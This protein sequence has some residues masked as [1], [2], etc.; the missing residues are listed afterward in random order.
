MKTIPVV[1][2]GA[3][4]TG[5]TAATLLAQYGVE[6]L[7][8]ERWESVYPQP[9][10]VALDDEVHR[11]LARLGLRDEFAAISRPHLGLRLLDRD[12]RVLTEFRRDVAQS[13]HGYPQG[14]MFDQPELEAILRRN[15]KQYGTVTLR[16]NAEVTALTQDADGVRVDFTDTATGEH[17]SV[18][19]AYILGCDGANSLT[20][21][22]IGATMQDLGFTQRWLVIDVV[23]EADL[24]QWEGVHQLSDPARAGTYMRVGKNRYRWEFQL[25]PGEAADDYRDMARLHP[26]I[27][28]WTGNVPVAELEI[29]RLAEYTFRAQL[30][31]R[32][33]DRR[34]FLLGDAAHLTPPFIGQGMCAGV[35]D[36]MNLAWKLAF[37]LDGTLPETVLDTYQ[38]ER[39][40]HA[41]AM[42]KLAK[43]IGTA[44]T[45]GGEVGNV[46][47]RAVAPRLHLV[48]GLTD[49]A[50]D[51]RTPP[52]HRSDLVVR[53]R[54]RRGLAGGLCPNALIDG[55]RRF[56]D[57]AAG[58][59]AIVTSIEPTPAQRADIE[60]RGA[61]L[62]VAR[63][64][65]DLHRWLRTGAACAAV[66]RPDG[67]VL[68]ASRRLLP[69]TIS[70]VRSVGR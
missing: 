2:V 56:D 20:R 47:R 37:V 9:R 45:A 48:P 22:S 7:I 24:D 39:R 28:P 1:I 30:A 50:T 62:I 40:H 29:I 35:R 26:L 14:S 67:T 11:I 16:G 59:F 10:A 5:L 25:T 6:C 12:M 41:R 70:A 57:V 31:D 36:A 17:E 63:P 15:L 4:P 55:G 44:M 23:T 3:G 32:W 38:I 60:R 65:S 49:L 13:R 61:V 64:G 46:I 21:A 43:F 33:R 53:P 27:S 34:M 18:R 19:A 58:R 54:L 66:V 42:I 68:R 51:S 52:L 8:L 69:Q